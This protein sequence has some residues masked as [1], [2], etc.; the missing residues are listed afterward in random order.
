MKVKKH[1]TAFQLANR[2]CKFIPELEP[3]AVLNGREHLG[4]RFFDP[5]SF[6]VWVRF[7][8]GLVIDKKES[9]SCVKTS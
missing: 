3:G 4:G 2:L 5:S 1:I 9:V 6:D 8:V 7:F